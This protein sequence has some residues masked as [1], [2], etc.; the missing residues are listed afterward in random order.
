MRIALVMLDQNYGGIQQNF[1]DHSIELSNRGF[2]VLCVI[3]NKSFVESKLR[4]AGISSIAIINNRI[5]FHDP[6]AIRQIGKALDEFFHDPPPHIVQSFGSRATL[7]ASRLKSQAR[8]WPLIASLPNSINHKYYKGA[9]IL[10]PSTNQMATSNFHKNLVDPVF[11]EVIPHFSSVE[12]A[13]ETV[14]RSRILK[15]FAAGRFVRKKGFD[16]LLKAIPDV[17]A[18][19]C[20]IQFQIAGDGPEFD[21]LKMLQTELKLE[22]KVQFLGF[23]NDVPLLMKQSDLFVVPSL[24]EPFGII[25]LEAMATGIPIVTTRNNGA[26]HILNGDTAIFVDIASPNALSSGILEAIN[27][28]EATFERSKNALELFRNHYTPD[29]VMPKVLSLYQTV[30]KDFLVN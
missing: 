21:E 29:A 22:D 4:E 16:F 5:G 11:S 9:D 15:I 20:R 13:S 24:S 17:L 2:P 7:F 6:F 10:V 27:N 23:R 1:L 28:P 8:R 19:D 26:L 14:N 30:S 25:L 18:G 12:P 3:R